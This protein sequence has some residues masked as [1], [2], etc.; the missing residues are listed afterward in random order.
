MKDRHET[1]IIF[2]YFEVELRYFK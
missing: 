2:L 1:P